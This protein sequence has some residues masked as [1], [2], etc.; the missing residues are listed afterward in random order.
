MKAFYRLTLVC[1]SADE[2]KLVETALSKA[3]ISA[4]VQSDDL[5]D[6][7]ANVR[8]F[9]SRSVAA[10]DTS[11]AP[12][13]PLADANM[14]TM[15]LPGGRTQQV[16][17]EG[18][19]AAGPATTGGETDSTGTPW[20]VRIHS[21]SKDKSAKTG[22]WRR[23]RNVEDAEFYRISAEL[24]GATQV[25]PKSAQLPP[26]PAATTQPNMQFQQPQQP[27]AFQQFQQQPTQPHPL[28][29]LPTQPVMNQYAPQGSAPVQAKPMLNF[30]HFQQQLPAV[31]QDLTAK[32]LINPAYMAQ[33]CQQLQIN[34]LFEVMNDQNKAAQLFQLM[35]DDG[36][37]GLAQY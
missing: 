37:I 25:L 35:L 14:R 16:P 36:I 27:Q 28:A 24:K 4:D 22:E 18:A 15:H 26:P 10:Q 17:V 21:A 2:L 34:H 23:R 8:T 12:G 9:R 29:S 6:Q 1:E 32:Q 33:K 11:P 13:A 7:P 3:G 30:P 5:P 31:I 19:T 20:D